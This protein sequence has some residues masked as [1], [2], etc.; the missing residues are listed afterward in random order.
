V[1]YWAVP[2]ADVFNESAKAIHVPAYH[3]NVWPALEHRIAAELLQA[4]GGEQWARL[5]A[6]LSKFTDLTQPLPA[7]VLVGPRG[8]WKSRLAQILARFWSTRES[9]NPCAATQVLGRFSRPLLSN[10]VIHTDEVM[11]KSESGRAIPEIYRESIMS[12]VHMV[13][14]K[15]VDPVTLHT[16]TRHIISVNDLDQV[17][18]GGEVDAASVEATVERYLVVDIDGERMA[19]FEERW[20]GTAELTALREGSPLLEHVAWLES[21][22]TYSSTCRLFVDTG[23]DADVLLRARFAD[24]TLVMCMAI[25]VESLLAEPSHSHVGQLHRLPLVCDREGQL[26]L[27]P[28]RIVEQWAD[29]KLTAGSG[30]K[31]PSVHRVGHLL[32]KAGIKL[33]A[34]ERACDSKTWKAWAVSHERLREYLRVEGSHSWAEVQSAC[35]SVFGV[36]I[37][38]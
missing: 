32:R 31:K 13:E 15:G 23:T 22:R 24:D 19:A 9:G 7:L 29:S 34:L 18:G 38:S 6:W 3:W 2:P 17:F 28:G 8:T 10:P 33:D 35:E 27:A 20:K 25:A 14:A 37:S 21:V 4:I 36:S 30:L 5:D 26:R 12:R 1:N 11:A 16:A